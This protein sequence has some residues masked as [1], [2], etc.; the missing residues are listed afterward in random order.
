MKR[1]SG[2]T[3]LTFGLFVSL[4]ASGQNDSITFVS[5]AWK[6]QT[7]S[8][9]IVWKQCLFKG[10]LFQSSQSINILEVKKRKKVSFSIG[11]EIKALKPTSE[12]GKTSGAIA[13]LNGTFFNMKDGGSV[14]YIKS[15]GRIVNPNR[16]EKRIFHQRAALAIKN[17]KLKIEKWDGSEQWETKIQAEDIMVSGPLL[18]SRQQPETLDSISFS[19]M[20]HPRTAVVTTANRTLLITIDGRHENAAGMN[21]FE[22]AKIVRWLKANDALNLDGGGST[23]LWIYNQPEGGVV[24]YPSDNKL[25]DHAGERKV[26]NV[27]L[28]KTR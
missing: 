1:A 11:Y 22:L 15:G 5:A 8:K 12:F 26:A 28:V 14:D 25:W 21:L 2:I 19:V 6:T 23:T 20:R 27:L 3:I 17:G 13:A 7:I 10:S 9:G 24:N 4:G 16:D 18:I